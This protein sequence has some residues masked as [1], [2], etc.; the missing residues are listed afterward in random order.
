MNIKPIKLL[1]LV[2]FL[3]MFS[4]CDLVEDV[5][6][7]GMW[8]TILAIV[9]IAAIIYALLTAVGYKTKKGSTV[10]QAEK[11]PENKKDIR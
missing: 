3:L 9:I 2:P 1:F 6:K 8:F 10:M 7:A 5:F 11:V 4:S